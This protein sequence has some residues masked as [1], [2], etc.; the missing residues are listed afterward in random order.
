MVEAPNTALWGHASVSIALQLFSMRRLGSIDA[1]LEASRNAGFK[2]VECLQIHINE[3]SIFRTMLDV[4]GLECT[5]LHVEYQF[6]IDNAGAILDAC[7]IVG[8]RSVFVH[9]LR[10]QKVRDASQW[11]R[12]G[13]CLGILAERFFGSGIELGF[14][15]GGECFDILNSGRSPIEELFRADDSGLLRWQADIGWIRFGGADPSV[16]L[17]RLKSRLVAA[18]IKDVAISS[19]NRGYV[20]AEVG[21]GILVLPLLIRSAVQEGAR[22]LIAEHDDPEHPEQFAKNAYLYLSRFS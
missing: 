6:L 5:T 22:L 4:R 15:N 19:E 11:A 9:D 2:M 14:H 18:H 17:R 1:Q 13:A 21:D 3:P 12:A 8:I 10:I 20:W 7:L 16:W